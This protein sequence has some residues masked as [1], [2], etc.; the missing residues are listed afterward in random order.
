LALALVLFGQLVLWPGEA[1]AAV[2]LNVSTTADI[3]T[4]AGAAFTCWGV[5]AH[6]TGSV[7][8]SPSSMKQFASGVKPS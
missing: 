5:S 4:N 3:A 1:S 6:A 7:P 8:S 2:T